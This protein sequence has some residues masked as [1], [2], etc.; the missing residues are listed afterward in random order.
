MGKRLGR[1]SR[2]GEQTEALEDLCQIADDQ[3]VDLVLIAGDV[4]DHFN[5]DTASTELFY[6]TLK[7]LTKGGAR[8]VIA[9]AGN[10]DSGERLSAPDP[11]ARAMGIFLIGQPFESLRAAETDQG[12]S[13]TP[14]VDGMLEIRLPA[15]KDYPLRL[16]ATPYTNEFRLKQALDS[17]DKEK[18]L[19]EVLRER[20]DEMAQHMDDTGFNVLMTHMFVVNAGEPLP[21]EPSDEKPI[22][23]VGGTQAIYT[24]AF[25]EALD[26]VALGHLHG[27]Q[28]LSKNVCPKVY[29]SSLLQYSFGESGATGLVAIVDAKPGTPAVVSPMPLK[30]GKPLLRFTSEGVDEAIVW[31]EAHPEAWVELTIRSQTFL[32]AKDRQ[33]LQAAHAGIV[34]IIPEISDQEM[35]RGLSS[36]VDLALDR[37]ALFYRYFEHRHGQTPSDDI[38]ALFKEVLNGP[39]A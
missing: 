12:V 5:P 20:W 30:A 38:K 1:F 35:S 6:R 3:Q 10:H 27:Y 18:E 22:L 33:R 32:T 37:E 2:L 9:I 4:F 36:E 23:H 11:L 14:I 7:R 39:S 31:L 13:V 8:P 21:E 25:P 19:R 16:I 29:A 15:H 17:E 24:D 26:Y 28:N 34:Q